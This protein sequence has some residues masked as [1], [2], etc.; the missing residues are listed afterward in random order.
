MPERNDAAR[1][2]VRSFWSGTLT[3]GL[4]SIPVDLYAAARSRR[5]AMKLADR[6]GRP[7]G[8]EYYSDKHADALSQDE[9]V[10]G[11]ETEKGK[12]VVI[13]DEELEALAP[14]M[15]R[16]IELRRFVP[17]EEIP[18]AF[19]MRPYFVAPAGRTQ[20]AYQLLAQ[21][22]AKTG[23]AGVG[24]LVM[25]G[26]QHLV[27]ILSDGTLL[28]AHTLRFASELRSP[29]EIG[30]PKRA[31]LAAKDV[32]RFLAAIAP[33][34]RET[35]DMEE[36]SDRYAEALHELAGKKAKKQKAVVDLSAA[37]DEDDA[38]EGGG[39]VI[40]LMKLLKQRVDATQGRSAGRG[41]H[42]GRKSAQRR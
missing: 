30:F 42:P 27:A 1:M 23:R 41:R 34:T 22:M 5:T 39:K 9:L 11:Y 32:K 3:F 13:T 10:R 26:R 4:V 7:L 16:D 17:K 31:R 33:L 12:M 28:R 24:T 25:R 38:D 18:P 8:R 6:K 40:D 37:D 2:P 19:Y 21:V 36:L 20:K 29:E 14:D 15:T 35:L